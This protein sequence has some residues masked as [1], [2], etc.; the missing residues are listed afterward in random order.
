MK[1]K[2]FNEDKIVEIIIIP[3]IIVFALLVWWLVQASQIEP[4]EETTIYYGE[5]ISDEIP[6]ETQIVEN[7]VESVE[8]TKI[9]ET[10]T[11]TYTEKEMVLTAYCSCVECCDKDDRIT[12]IGTH[13]KQGRTIAVDPRYIPYG[14]EVI[15]DGVTYIAEDC[16][17]AIKG[18]RIDVYFDSHSEALE[19]GRQTK[20]VRV[21]L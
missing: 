4:E 10:D 7:S 6:T 21:M 14:T 9:P 20:I 2:S 1:N 17:G 19:F 8:N 5:F 11:E 12:A 16:G 15:I 13:A 18:D 3:V